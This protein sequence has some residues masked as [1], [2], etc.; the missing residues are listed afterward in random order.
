MKRD[1]HDIVTLTS[2][3]GSSINNATIFAILVMTSDHLK[4][5]I[6]TVEI[7]QQF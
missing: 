6:C 4:A 7:A 5:V 2:C 3:N 1:V